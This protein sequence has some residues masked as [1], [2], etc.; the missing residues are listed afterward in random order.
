MIPLY[1]LRSVFHIRCGET[2]GSGTAFTLNYN[3][4]Q[5]LVT[6]RHVV[7][8]ISGNTIDI[9]HDGE[10]KGLEVD[11]IGKGVGEIDVAVL[12]SPL[13]I[14][15]RDT[16]VPAYSTGMTIGQQVYFLGFPLDMRGGSPYDFPYPLA[17]SGV[18]SGVDSWHGANLLYVDGHANRGFSG[19]PLIYYQNQTT[20]MHIA[21]VIT[22][23]RIDPDSVNSGIGIAV[24][25]RHVIDLIN[26]NPGRIQSSN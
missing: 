16:V 3:D 9:F 14:G 23:F 2:S 1:V 8:S 22:S 13:A 10:W 21:G 12:S 19:G 20:N 24:D 15:P 25:I 5:Y 18:L 17:K 6:A 11:V 4:W 26:S 7:E